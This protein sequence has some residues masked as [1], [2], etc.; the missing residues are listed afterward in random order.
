MKTARP[1]K[2][3]IFGLLGLL[4]LVGCEEASIAEQAAK[5]ESKLVVNALFSPDSPWEVT[6]ST[7]RNILAEEE[8]FKNDT[9]INDAII[10]IEDIDSGELIELKNHRP[11]YYLNE[12]YFPEENHHYNIT[13]EA[14]GFDKISAE[15]IVPAKVNF[16]NYTLTKRID[17]A[18]DEHFDI[19][20]EIEEH[21][22][23]DEFIG[24]EA[25]LLTSNTTLEEDPQQIEIQSDDE[26]SPFDTDNDRYYTSNVKF[27]NIS[28]PAA[29]IGAN[30]DLDAYIQIKA[31]SVSKDYYEFFTKDFSQINSSISAQSPS[32]TNIGG[33]L[34]IFGG[35]TEV[36]Y[37]IPIE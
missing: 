26:Y 35:F 23:R 27:I 8:E 34:G 18:G 32:Y 24:W 29:T 10:Y 20:L 2:I 13:V 6:L 1:L 11:G 31:F 14:P 17:N 37:Q 4:A 28:I 16:T 30:V 21:K 3:F 9:N 5:F 33:G 25:Y 15:S 12:D 36:Q 19:H 7:T 22:D